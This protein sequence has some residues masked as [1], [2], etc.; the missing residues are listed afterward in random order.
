MANK[1]KKECSL[2]VGRLFIIKEP[3]KSQGLLQM[4]RNWGPLCTVGG[5]IRRTAVKEN[6]LVAPQKVTYRISTQPSNSRDYR[7]PQKFKADSSR[8]PVLS[9][10]VK[11]HNKGQNTTNSIHG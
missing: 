4:G 3:E 8:P 1:H 11:T 2:S 5:R 7:S 6:N 10:A 9:A